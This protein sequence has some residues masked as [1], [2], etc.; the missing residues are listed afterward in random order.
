[1]KRIIVAIIILMVNCALA[2]RKLEK[3]IP[4]SNYTSYI[5]KD[6]V[7]DTQAFKDI[8]NKKIYPDGSK[9][10][11]AGTKK[12]GLFLA[13]RSGLP[14]EGPAM[15][16]GD[17]YGGYI[18][19]ILIDE[20]SRFEANEAVL[21]IMVDKHGIIKGSTTK[22]MAEYMQERNKWAEWLP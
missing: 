18:L 8:N 19:Y 22:T 2:E 21:V 3:I 17:G 11:C 16:I 9:W 14:F 15:I 20:S 13:I 6:A 4:C 7:N 10:I 5:T 12:T 1:M